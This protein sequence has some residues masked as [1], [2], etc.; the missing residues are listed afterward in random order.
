MFAECAAKAEDSNL[1]QTC[2]V[3]SDDGVDEVGC[4]Y[5]YRGYVVWVY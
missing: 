5:C 2:A 1:G 4:S 3:S